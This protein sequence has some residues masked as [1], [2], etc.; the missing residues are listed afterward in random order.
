MSKGITPAR[1]LEDKVS[2]PIYFQQAEDIK[3]K[4]IKAEALL[5][6][7]LL[8]HT[9]SLPLHEVMPYNHMDEFIDILFNVD[10]ESDLDCKKVRKAAIFI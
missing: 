5:I 7:M 6:N 9:D 3:N 2:E 4:I 8:T 10:K 1:K